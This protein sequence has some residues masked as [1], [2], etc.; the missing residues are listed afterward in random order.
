[1]KKSRWIVIP[2]VAASF[3]LAVVAFAAKAKD[4]P[5]SATIDACKKK[6]AAVVFPHKK[7]VDAKLECAKCHH[8]QKDLK[9]GADVEVK[10]CSSCHLT[11]EK[12]ET[13]KCTETS[14]KKNPF[15][16]SCTGCHKE[17]KKGPTKC[18]EC[19]KK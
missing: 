6:K 9:A 3:A 19:H 5:E 2:V 1:M 11:P 14:S 13:P 4:A 15:H 16:I 8:T 17:Q 10:K 12:P 7:H 18:K